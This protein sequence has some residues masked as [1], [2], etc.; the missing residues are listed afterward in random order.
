MANNN[1]ERVDCLSVDEVQ[2]G[3]VLHS[4]PKDYVS[5]MT[6]DGRLDDID[7]DTVTYAVTPALLLSG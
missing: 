3:S 4:E 6:F 2:L 7:L 5:Q 1:H